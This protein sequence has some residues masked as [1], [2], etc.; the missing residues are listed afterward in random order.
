MD[1]KRL[2]MAALLSV[3]VLLLWQTIFPSAPRIDAPPTQGGA[4]TET[5]V[6]EEV[7]RAEREPPEFTATASSEME[8]EV[9]DRAQIEAAAEREVVLETDRF[10]AVFS[11]RGA[12]LVSF[13]S[14]IHSSGF[15]GGVDLVKR[16]AQPPYPFAIVDRAGASDPLN[17]ALFVVFE[18]SGSEADPIRFEYS[19]PQGRAEKSFWERPDG[20]LG[21]RLEVSGRSDWAF[22]LGPGVRNPELEEFE[23]RFARRG[24]VYMREQEVERLDSRKTEETERIAGSRTSWI[25]LEDTYFMAGWV[26]TGD[27]FEYALVRPVAGRI[28][29]SG[30]DAVFERMD[31]AIPDEDGVVRELELLI[32][33]GAE[34]L[35]GAAYL[36]AKQY[37]RLAELPNDLREAVNLGFFA[38]LAKPILFGLRWLHDS[39]TGNWGWAIIFMTVFIRLVLFPLTHKSFISMQ[40]MQEVNPKVQA[41]KQKY[42]GKLKDKR[43]RP[44]SEMQRKMNEE[45]MGLYKKE[46]VN[47]AGGCLPMLLQIPVLFA[48]YNLL[49]AAVELRHAPWILWIQDLS[50]PDPYYALPIIMGASQFVQQKIT[51]SAADPMQKRIFMLMPFFFTFL[52]LGFPSGMVLYWLTNN[53]LGIIQ[54]LGYKRLKERRA[55]KNSGDPK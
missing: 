33:S 50:A 30:I 14:K 41:I 18:G 26:V 2:F 5:D 21:V 34:V 20:M 28:V 12:Q 23:S 6:F 43:G 24:A 51:P 38:I 55:A 54:Q 15:G 1:N 52:F 37:D 48:F 11:N 25:G 39:V 8:P 45:V 42:R 13:V 53:V 27:P 44:N 7:V 3:G 29:G 49:S 16:R 31:G 9:G 19:G 10:R 36:G 17:E 46:G 22:L 32:A 40:K 4:F 35:E 47:P